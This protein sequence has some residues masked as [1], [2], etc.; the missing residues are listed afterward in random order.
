MSSSLSGKKILITRE[1]HQAKVFSD[2]LKEVGA[3]PLVA[4]LLSFQPRYSSEN[5]KMMQRLQDFTWVFF[6]SANG[7][8]FFFDQMIQ[9]GYNTNVLN[10]LHIAV[11][12]KKTEL[13]LHH[14]NFKAD[15]KPS[16][17][18]GSQMAK[19]FLHRYGNSGQILLVC[20]SKSRQ[21]IPKEL[22]GHHVSFE[23]LI[24]YDTLVNED[25]FTLLRSYL[26]Q[27]TIDAYT[28]TSPSTIEAFLQLIELSPLID[29]FVAKKRLC[30]C[31]GSTTQQK[32]LDEGFQHVLVPT[33]FTIEG[34][35]DELIKHFTMKG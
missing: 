13:M 8:K 32:A 9:F 16:H 26:K 14:Y 15:F 31:I 23:R 35:L 22:T 6:T 17:F 20:G 30:V 11:V 7:V 27:N 12:G 25:S 33:E 21:E 10:Q 29:E 5:Q 18:H 3:I 2:K 24:I 19:E 1:K 4:P 28:F 34:M